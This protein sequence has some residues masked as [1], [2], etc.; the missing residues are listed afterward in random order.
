MMRTGISRTLRGAQR[1]EGCIMLR[2]FTQCK[3][4]KERLELITN[5]ENYTASELNAICEILGLGETAESDDEK[6]TAIAAAIEENIK[7]E[8]TDDLKR[9]NELVA[10]VVEEEKP[11]PEEDENDLGF[12]TRVAAINISGISTR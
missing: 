11:E 4:N 6:L 3:S 10:A 2:E 12:L 5:A 7:K 9:S 8:A 1:N